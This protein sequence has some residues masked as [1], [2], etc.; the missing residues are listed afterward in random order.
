M[1]KVSQ[2]SLRGMYKEATS[3][4]LSILDSLGVSISLEPE[5]GNWKMN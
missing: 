2:D 4:G 5:I 1:A 3:F